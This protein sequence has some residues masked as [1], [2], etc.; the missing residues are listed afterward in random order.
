[1]CRPTRAFEHFLFM[2]PA[3]YR[4]YGGVDFPIRYWRTK[5]G[6]EVDFIWGEGD[7]AIEAK[8]AARIDKEDLRG[9]MAFQKELRPGKAIL[10]C[11]ETSPRKVGS[12]DIRPW[13][14]FLERLWAGK[15]IQG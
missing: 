12:I 5:S 3:A 2:K 4:S 9:L 14:D 6:A 1:M 15:I 11:N 13:R 7:V 8:S 10:V